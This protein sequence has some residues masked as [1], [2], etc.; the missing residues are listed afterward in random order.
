VI[1]RIREGEVNRQVGGS[2]IKLGSRLNQIIDVVNR[3]QAENGELRMRL[4]ALEGAARR[5]EEDDDA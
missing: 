3:L 2:S 5:G 1:P 4:E